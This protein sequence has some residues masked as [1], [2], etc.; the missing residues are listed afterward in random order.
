MVISPLGAIHTSGKISLRITNLNQVHLIT[1]KNSQNQD[2]DQPYFQVQQTGQ[3]NGKSKY[4]EEKGADHEGRFQGDHFEVF[5]NDR[6]L[7]LIQ[8]V[9]HFSG[10]ENTP[11]GQDESEYQ[12]NKQA[13]QV[14]HLAQ[15]IKQD[16]Y[17]YQ[18]EQF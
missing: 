10:K 4:H 11:V 12:D 8:V 17:S 18:Q 6:H 16:Q 9:T 1:I 13:R 3:D 14:E 2:A 5:E 15:G 7:F